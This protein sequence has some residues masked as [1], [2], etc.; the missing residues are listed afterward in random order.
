MMKSSST[1]KAL[2][3]EG[4]SPSDLGLRLTH[5]SVARQL[6][7]VNMKRIEFNKHPI[8]GLES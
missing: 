5:V 2:E 3:Y 8:G 4:A 1:L 7:S 6:D